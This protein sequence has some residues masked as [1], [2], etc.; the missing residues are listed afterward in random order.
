VAAQPPL[1]RLERDLSGLLHPKSIVVF[2]ASTRE[3][4]LIQ[5]FFRN[6]KRIGYSGAIFGVNPFHVGEIDG[7]QVVAHV[8]GLPY[9]PDAA[10]IA[11]PASRVVEAMESAAAIGVKNYVVITSG[12][13]EIGS[14]GARLEDAIVELSKREGLCVSGPNCVGN[15]SLHDRATTSI[16]TV[17]ESNPFVPGEVALVGQSG[18]I[19][20]ITYSLG[21]AEGVGFSHVI[22]SGNEAVLDVS[23]FATYLLDDPHTKVIC[24]YVE[25]FKDGR[26]LL[27]VASLARRVGKH[28]VV[29]KG[30]RRGA[31]AKAALSHTG[32]I[33]TDDA[34]VSD[35]FE[36]AGIV[37]A[38][39][40]TELLAAAK[41]L[42]RNTRVPHSRRVVVVGASGGLAVLAADMA[43]AAGLELP[44]LQDDT[45]IQLQTL[46]P[47]YASYRNPV[48]L[49]PSVFSDA[50]RIAPVI[51]TAAADP[52][53]D[54]L[55]IVSFSGDHL[56]LRMAE[57]VAP[58][59]AG[60]PFSFAV[61]LASTPEIHGIFDRFGVACIA[62]PD[63]AFQMLGRLIA[64][65]AAPA[66]RPTDTA[67]RWVAYPTDSDRRVVL[68]EDKI[69]AQ[70]SE[71]GLAVARSVMAHSTAEAI[72]A[73]ARLGYPVALKAISRDLPH[74]ASVGG[75]ALAL[76]SDIAVEA[77][78]IAIVQRLHSELPDASLE[79]CLVQEMLNGVE[80]LIGIVIDR[81][82]GPVITV[83]VGGSMVEV[84]RQARFAP[85]PVSSATATQL[86][87]GVSAFHRLLSGPQRH[88]LA[89]YVTAVSEWW[90]PHADSL[91]ELDLNPVIVTDAGPIAADAL[92]V[93]CAH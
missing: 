81:A 87:D 83:G 26:R 25:N 71:A 34:I 22:T 46:L 5:R 73:A 36:L 48:D 90:E 74:R 3:D 67:Q 91:L 54:A 11:V 66:L 79:G 41:M 63:I 92:C 10:I 61:W 85:L 77:A 56:S 18:G 51:A 4:S 88:Q 23:Q 65:G 69:G 70:L 75:V 14:D 82:F 68:T 55:A 27:E 89:L 37:K 12:F 78:Y 2:G 76:S 1:A 62:D 17:F 43:E 64:A 19:V 39:S 49:T 72:A 30:G 8:S 35:L 57:A 16:S 20:A 47:S 29:M 6:V 40:P 86:V 38:D 21:V 33:A 31:A 13:R 9:A 60:R 15:V 7:H 80:V 84:V 58:V 93:M 24:V 52:G 45:M 42:I 44:V 28:I 50:S 32:A 53:C 59:M